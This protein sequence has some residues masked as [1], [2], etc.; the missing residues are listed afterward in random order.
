MR[1]FF[2][3]FAETMTIYNGIPK[4]G[5]DQGRKRRDSTLLLGIKENCCNVT[6]AEKELITGNFPF[7]YGIYYKG[8]RNNNLGLKLELFNLFYCRPYVSFLHPFI[9][10]LKRVLQLAKRLLIGR[11]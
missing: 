11:I 10:N 4:K 3:T 7:R 9:H 5:M 1:K 8:L 2:F 6:L